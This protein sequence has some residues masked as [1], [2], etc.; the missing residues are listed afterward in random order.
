LSPLQSTF[1]APFSAPAD[2]GFHDSAGE[3]DRRT[4]ERGRTIRPVLH[5]A[6]ASGIN[7]EAHRPA[8]CRL[9][10]TTV[11]RAGRS[12]VVQALPARARTFDSSPRAHTHLASRAGLQVLDRVGPCSWA[13]AFVAD[14]APGALHKLARS[15]RELPVALSKRGRVRR[16]SGVA[17]KPGNRPDLRRQRKCTGITRGRSNRCQSG[18][19]RETDRPNGGEPDSRG[20]TREFLDRGQRLVTSEVQP[21]AGKRRRATSP[22][23]SGALDGR[24]NMNLAGADTF[25]GH[26]LVL[27]AAQIGGRS[28]GRLSSFQHAAAVP[29]TPIDD[30]LLAM[31]S[32]TRKQHC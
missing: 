8:R 11:G 27:V 20:R 9:P 16:S 14:D 1:S 29:V 19:C 5:G 4:D 13:L 28:G 23:L 25:G 31:A 18:S 30:K 17:E 10:S 22:S 26:Q 12:E 6:H 32:L 24:M 7:V 21:A 15:H 3:K 2:I